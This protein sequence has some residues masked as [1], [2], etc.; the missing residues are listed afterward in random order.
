MLYFASF[1]EYSNVDS[2]SFWLFVSM[3]KLTKTVF[4]PY[5]SVFFI[6]IISCRAAGVS[7][8]AVS[9]VWVCSS[10]RAKINDK[11]LKCPNPQKP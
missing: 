9:H 5:V 4:D 3:F 6:S 11:L 7:S 10:V 8:H 2:F 1:G